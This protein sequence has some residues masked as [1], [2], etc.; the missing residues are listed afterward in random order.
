[1]LFRIK[2]RLK[3]CAR[4]VGGIA[5][6]SREVDKDFSYEHGPML[7]RKASSTKKLYLPRAAVNQRRSDAAV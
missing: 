4:Q 7:L 1:M 6:R 2:V 5:V 3:E